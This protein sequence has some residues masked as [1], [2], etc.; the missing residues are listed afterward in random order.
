MRMLARMRVC[1]VYLHP[2]VANTTSVSQEAD[3]A[4]GT[5]KNGFR[6]NITGV[7]DQR[8]EDKKST[9]LSPSMVGLFLFG[10]MDPETKYVVQ[11][12][13]YEDA[14]HRDANLCTWHKVGAVVVMVNGE[15]R[16][17]RACLCNPQIN[18]LTL[19][20]LWWFPTN[21]ILPFCRCDAKRET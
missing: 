17:T 6:Q 15:G 12:N 8:T 9:S 16:V 5:M 11:R 14:F 7:F 10:R 21:R 18:L 13:V 2:G 19:F 4:Y 20:V 1:G 3:C